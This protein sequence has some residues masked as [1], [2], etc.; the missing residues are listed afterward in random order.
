M[1]KSSLNHKVTRKPAS[2]IR[3]VWWNQSVGDVV[4]H[5]KAKGLQDCAL[6]RGFIVKDW[7][8]VPPVAYSK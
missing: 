6:M 7:Q 5:Y 8:V 1:L 4:K 2:M 3:V